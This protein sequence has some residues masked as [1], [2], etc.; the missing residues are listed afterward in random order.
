VAHSH[1]IQAAFFAKRGFYRPAGGPDRAGPRPALCRDES[2][3][4]VSGMGGLGKSQLAVEFCY[5]Y[6][7]FFGEYIGYRPTWIYRP[8]LPRTAWL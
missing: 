5:R 8:K 2:C 4:V 3:V 6:G 7:R 1:R